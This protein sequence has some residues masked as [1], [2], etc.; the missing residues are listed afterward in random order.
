MRRFLGSR[1]GVGLGF[2][3][4]F[5]VGVGVGAAG[6]DSEAE[7]EPA[8]NTVTAT[9][10][11]GTITE[12]VTVTNEVTVQETVTTVKTQVRVKPPPSRGVKV[13]YGDWK[14]LFKIHG[15]QVTSTYGT[16]SVIGQLEYLGGGDCPLGYVEV[17]GTFFNSG[18]KIVSTGLWNTTTRPK[19]ARLPMEVLSTDE[20]G[21]T[22]AELVVTGASCQ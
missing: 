3:V 6:G 4:I 19:G 13:N 2:L 17:S 20:V 15:A 21:A 8:A 1:W 5:L 14:G 12:E 11:A 9:T 18:G 10:A 16:P 7:A 22:R